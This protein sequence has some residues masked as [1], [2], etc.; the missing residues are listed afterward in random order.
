MNRQSSSISLQTSTWTRFSSALHCFSQFHSALLW[1]IE[2]ATIFLML[3]ILPLMHPIKEIFTYVLI[4]FPNSKVEFVFTNYTFSYQKL[5]NVFLP[6]CCNNN[7]RSCIIEQG[8]KNKP[9]KLFNAHEFDI[10][11]E[12]VDRNR[13]DYYIQQCC[14][15]IRSTYCFQ[16]SYGFGAEVLL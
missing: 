12:I 7:N 6:C 5:T 16:K 9:D 1:T 10:H 11:Q 13:F 2:S 4:H 8:E 3:L 14:W 15:Y